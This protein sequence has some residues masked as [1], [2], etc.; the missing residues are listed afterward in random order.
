MLANHE[1]KTLL[2]KHLDIH[3]KALTA[4]DPDWKTFHV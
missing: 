2:N 4:D 3:Y 1:V